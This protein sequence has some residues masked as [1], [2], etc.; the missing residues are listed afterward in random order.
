[1]TTTPVSSVDGRDRIDCCVHY[2][3]SSP[4]DVLDYIEPGWREYVLTRL[5][6]PWQDH[7]RG[8]GERPAVLGPI[9]L[10]PMHQYTYPGPAKLAN[11]VHAGE[12]P[13]TLVERHLDVHGISAALLLHELAMMIPGIPNPRLA[14][15]LVT[16]INDWT[17]ERWL[18]ELPGRLWA[19]VLVANQMPDEAAA[20]IRRVGAHPGMAAVLMAANGLGKPFGHPAYHPIYEAATELDLPI[21]IYAGPEG[22]GESLTSPHGGGPA[23]TYSDYATL[24]SH[25]TAVHVAS[26]IGQGV[27]VRYPQLRVLLIGSGATWVAPFL[28]NF[29]TNYRGASRDAPWLAKLPSE[30]F[31]EHFRIATYPLDQAPSAEALIRYYA[32]F[33]DFDDLLCFASGFPNH[34]C[35]APG[36]FAQSLPPSWRPKVMHD[37]AFTLLR[38]V[39]AASVGA[40]REAISGGMP[41]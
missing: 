9:P 17:I 11:G 3:W 20:E 15:A 24:I 33:G 1:M 10:A 23:A 37:N 6:V 34:D 39:A 35:V 32:A 19:T 27:C 40:Q 8:R 26:L 41:R 21:V 36:P 5:S 13:A 4:T 25:S 12:T 22:T 38:S 30:Y 16:A 29:D 14:A 2:S 18:G 7:L 31:R 28:W